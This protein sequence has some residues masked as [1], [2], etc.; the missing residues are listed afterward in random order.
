ME[1]W[2]WLE[3]NLGLRSIAATAECAQF[4][5][6]GTEAPPTFT[7]RPTRGSKAL[8]PSANA[9]E[10][11]RR[12]DAEACRSNRRSCELSIAGH[13]RGAPGMSGTD[14]KPKR[15][16]YSVGGAAM[17]RGASSTSAKSQL[18]EQLMCRR[19]AE[20]WRRTC[21]SAAVSTR[22]VAA[23]T[24]K[25]S[26][27]GGKWRSGGLRFVSPPPPP[28][29]PPRPSATELFQGTRPARTPGPF[30]IYKPAAC[31]ASAEQRSA[32]SIPMVLWQ[33]GR[34]NDRRAHNNASA[35]AAR[36]AHQ[37]IDAGL[38]LV[39]HNDSA[40]RAFV[41]E[42]CPRAI[43]AYD[44]LRP[45]AYKA[46]L[47]RYCVMWAKGGIY[48]DAED[49]P[50]VP[51]RSLLRPCDTLVL[52][53]DWCPEHWRARLTWREKWGSACNH[54]AVQI[55][56]MAAA[57]RRPFFHCA[58]QHA[59]RN[60]ESGYYGPGDLFVTGPPL[61]GSCLDRLHKGMEYTMEIAQGKHALFVGSTPVIRTHA[62][63]AAEEARATPAL[64]HARRTN[65]S[66][67]GG[68]AAMPGPRPTSYA[69]MWRA[70]DILKR[71]C[72]VRDGKL[73]MADE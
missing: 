5:L 21:G 55:S 37:M 66:G 35:V 26:D 14:A 19:R 62:W 54:T 23:A 27:C 1:R 63:S 6:T 10:R 44:C 7:R 18:S 13:C 69:R 24:A 72:S 58:L 48:L 17:A 2:C 36:V 12:K 4:N 32:T 34:G 45:H 8:L 29:P 39:W 15:V 61:A 9:R 31:G 65:A 33:T 70:R 53:R 71:R 42:H 68:R 47:W 51:L 20:A 30:P 73:H 3:R 67:I 49:V 56:F 11:Q 41:A 60:I 40:A 46:D 25:D 59:V 50:I 52:A 43:R 64:P 38:E 22:L 57:P 16:Q 28:L